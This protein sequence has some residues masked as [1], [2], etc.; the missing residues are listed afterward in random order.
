MRSVQRVLLA[1]LFWFGLTGTTF[2]ACRVG[3]PVLDEFPP[4]RAPEAQDGVTSTAVD[5]PVSGRMVASDPDGD[6]ISYTIT[7]APTLGVVQLVDAATGDYTYLSGIAGNDSFEFRVTDGR[8][9]SNTA[10]ISITVLNAQISWLQATESVPDASEN[11]ECGGVAGFV[12]VDTVITDPFDN[13]HLLRTSDAAAGLSESFDGGLTWI[14]S[15]V[16]TLLSGEV[17]SVEFSELEAGLIYV[18]ASAG[19]GGQ[20]IRHDLAAGWNI[21]AR[22]EFE[23]RQLDITGVDTVGQVTIAACTNL[24]RTPR[25]G[26]DHRF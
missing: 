11:M 23:I 19:E 17:F 26:H 16:S 8:R 5:V 20:L 24:D 7:S 13:T 21:A 15:P 14:V 25:I 22:T 10:N 2:F 18:A 4:N 6:D 1:V 12:P 9:N 3:D